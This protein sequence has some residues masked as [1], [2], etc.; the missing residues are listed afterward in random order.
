MAA[1]QRG[2]GANPVND[3]GF[4]GFQ[5]R[6]GDA[7]VFFDAG[8]VREVHLYLP[9]IRRPID[10]ENGLQ[11]RLGLLLNSGHGST[12]SVMVPVCPLL[13][14]RQRFTSRIHGFMN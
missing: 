12:A 1:L 8:F 3:P 6:Q 13:G 14:W 7:L 11:E 4:A 9:L 2:T 10:V 5:L